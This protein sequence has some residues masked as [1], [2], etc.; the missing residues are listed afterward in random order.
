M[1]C[2]SCKAYIAENCKFCGSCGAKQEIEIQAAKILENTRQSSM[3]KK[4][5]IDTHPALNTLFLVTHEFAEILKN[6]LCDVNGYESN[7]ISTPG[8]NHQELANL[9]RT[10]LNQYSS[11]C[12]VGGFGDISPFQV[13]NPSSSADDPDEWCFTDAIFGCLSFNEAD[14][15]TAIPSVAVSR[16]PILDEY[17][18]QNLLKSDELNG[19]LHDQFC[20]GVTAELWQPATAKIFEEAGLNKS[21]LFCTPDWEEKTISLKINEIPYTN[22]ARVYLFNVHGGSDSTEWVGDSNEKRFEPVALTPLALKDMSDSI[23]ISEACYGGAMQYEE[24][25]IVEQFF[26]ANGQAF[27]GCSV[28]AYGNPG[29]EDMPLFSAD[30]IALSIIKN[31]SQGISFGE[32]LNAAKKETLESALLGFEN[33]ADM[34]IQMMGKYAAKAILSFNAFGCPWLK[35]RDISSEY[36]VQSQ[37]ANNYS[38]TT[39]SSTSERL[40]DIRSR[41]NTRIQ[42]RTQNIKQR[43][44]PIRN[45]YRSKLP[46]KTQLFL[47]STDESLAAFRFFE[48]AERIKNFF[49]SRNINIEKCNFYKSNKSSDN[50]YLVSASR[51]DPSSIEGESYAMITNSKGALKIILG[52]K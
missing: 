19:C 40:N 49:T 13:P 8:N 1:F 26:S 16:I 52:S 20:F 38:V 18:I 10:K 23:L 42:S 34:D 47:L 29:Y 17:T 48:D 5:R 35:F 51:N 21:V 44:N 28:V 30:V 22:K 15:E 50:G 41:L 39:P 2:F 36:T 33:E 37:A 46:L 7:I 11:I 14:V 43:L 9:C 4:E 27:I 6:L 3:I 25:S 32:S 31:L 12:I 45:S 24:P